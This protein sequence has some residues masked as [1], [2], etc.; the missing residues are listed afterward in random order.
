[1]NKWDIKTQALLAL[2]QKYAKGNNSLATSAPPRCCRG[3]EVRLTN[4]LSGGG[5]LV[6]ARE[7]FPSAYLCGNSRHY[8]P[9][10]ANVEFDR[11]H[12]TMLGEVVR[13]IAS[14]AITSFTGFFYYNPNFNPLAKVWIRYQSSTK[15]SD[16]M[17]RE[18]FATWIANALIALFMLYYTEGRLS[19]VY[20]PSFRGRSVSI[21]FRGLSLARGC[22]NSLLYTER[23]RTSCGRGCSRSVL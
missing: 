15:H 7:L 20:T 19:Y 5:A 9:I 17:I 23:N 18:L 22:P 6:V 16:G 4:Q 2:P 8:D 3:W 13:V 21:P 12:E 14:L 11:P 10:E 1:M